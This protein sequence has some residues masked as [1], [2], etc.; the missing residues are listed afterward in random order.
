[1]PVAATAAPV[2]ESISSVASSVGTTIT[3]TA[4]SGVTS[5]DTLLMMAT[6]RAATGN[7]WT[8]PT[9]WTRVEDSLAVVDGTMHAA[10]F[11]RTADGTATDTPSLV[12]NVD[13]AQGHQAVIMRITGTDG[14]DVDGESNSELSNT[15]PAIPSVSVT[16]NDSLAICVVGFATGGAA[17]T[18][19]WPSPWSEQI[20]SW[21]SSG[22]RHTMTIGSY[23]ASSGATTADNVT[24][25]SDRQNAVV[26]VV[27]SPSAGGG[28]IQPLLHYNRQNQGN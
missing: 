13:P 8:T 1:M 11:T 21:V 6:C 23:T 15:Q 17:E 24:I 27:L 26:L 18:S 12:F 20:D 7:D 16:D 2:I 14:V 25:A 4:P 28:T 9:G 19:T 22:I 5:G 3:T 10:V